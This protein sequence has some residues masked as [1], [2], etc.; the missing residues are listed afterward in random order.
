MKKS[1]FLE[2]A[3]IATI[4]IIVCKIIGL[5]YVI[6]FYKIIGDRGGALYGY[7]YSIYA[8]FLSLSSSGIPIAISKIVSEYNSLEYYNTKERSYKIGVKIISLLGGF[9][10]VILMLFANPIASLILGNLQGGNT[11]GG[12]AMVIRVIATTLLIVPLLS[13][14]RGYLQG[15]NY[16]TPPSIA[17]VIEQLVRVLVIVIGSFLALKVFKTSLEIAVGIAVFGATIGAVASYIYLYRK[18]RKSKLQTDIPITR[19]EAKITNKDIVKKIIFYALPFVM[20]DLIN[21]A[22]STVD[23]TTVVNTMVKLGFNDIA[24]VTIGVITT[25]ASK[26]NMIVISIALGI[27]ISLIPSMTKSNVKKDMKDISK[28]IN[29][30]LQATLLT[31]LPM[32]IGLSFL[33]RPTWVIFYGYNE[34]SITIF[35]AFIFTSL[36]YSFYMILTNAAQTLDDTKL[37]LGTLLVSFIGKVLLNVPMMYLCKHIGI[38]VYYGPIITTILTQGIGILFVT[39]VLGKKYQVNYRST[40]YNGIKIVLSA[41]IMLI[42]L[43]IVNIFI[44]LDSVTRIKALIEVLIYALLGGIVYLTAIYKS[45]LIDD[46]FG[47]NFLKSIIAKIPF[48]NKYKMR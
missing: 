31:C 45:G 12:V 13:V 15:H 25:W 40:I 34:L 26:L 9:F 20:I 41:L 37:S 33:A 32:V 3:M 43:K 39:Y 19:A 28:K 6:P 42:V 23:T 24:E 17:N 8:I 11:I 30:S 16:I 21:S 44:P 47:K 1:S 10:F 7:A 29:Q 4:G 14:T 22:Y 46:I 2:G 18:I 48:K 5:I 38:G 36:T 35:E 27:T